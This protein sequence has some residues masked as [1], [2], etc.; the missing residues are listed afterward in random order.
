MPSIKFLDVVIFK[1]FNGSGSFSVILFEINISPA[2]VPQIGNPS[3]A[4]GYNYVNLVLTN[5]FDIA[6]LSPPGITRESQLFS[7]S[8]DLTSSVST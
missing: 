8:I 3:K 1:S 5:N 2:H 4:F 6:V 7:S